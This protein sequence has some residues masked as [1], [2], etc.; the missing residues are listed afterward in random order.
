MHIYIH[1]SRRKLHK[2]HKKRKFAYH[3]IVY[4]SVLHR[5]TY[6]LVLNIS[7]VYKKT[8]IAAIIL[9]YIAVADNPVNFHIPRC[10]IYRQNIICRILAVNRHYSVLQLTVPRRMQHCFA[11]LYQSER[12]IWAGQRKT[13]YY[14]PYVCGL[15][16]RFF[17]E[18]SAYRRIKKQICNSNSRS[19]RAAR[20]AQ[21]NHLSAGKLRR[22]AEIRRCRPCCHGQMR[23]SRNACQCFSAKAQRVHI[24]EFLLV[25]GFAGAVTHKRKP[26]FIRLYTAAVVRYPYICYSALARLHGYCS[27]S[28]IYAVFAEFLYYASRTLH[29]LA[30]RYFLSKLFAHYS[31]ASHQN[32]PSKYP[33]TFWITCLTYT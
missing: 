13:G 11:V 5:C 14:I 33:L 20:L 23:N 6:N 25:I 21:R 7:S 24:E 29:Y 27:A 3:Y 9:F 17:K 2:Q 32:S 4:I 30:C 12:H 19:P 26:Y 8:L 15:L 16:R 31:N 18:F 1:H 22:H 28:R 10:V